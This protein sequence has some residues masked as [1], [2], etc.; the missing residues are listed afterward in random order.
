MGFRLG[1]GIVPVGVLEVDILTIG[2]LRLAAI[3]ECDETFTF[4]KLSLSAV[5]A[6][7]EHLNSF[8]MILEDFP[9]RDK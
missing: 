6:C 4:S 7:Y 8:T 1:I 2:D 3:S 5:N 9:I